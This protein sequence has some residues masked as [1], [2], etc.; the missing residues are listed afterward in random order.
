M[1]SSPAG[2]VAIRRRRLITDRTGFPIRSGR[3]YINGPPDIPPHLSWISVPQS[4]SRC[5]SIKTGTMILQATTRLPWKIGSL[6]TLRILI[7][8]FRFCVLH[9]SFFSNDGLLV[10]QFMI[11]CCVHPGSETSGTSF[12]RRLR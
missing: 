11:V 4:T 8:S 3:T 2:D 1:C 10:F 5:L 12:R 6:P 7:S 9:S